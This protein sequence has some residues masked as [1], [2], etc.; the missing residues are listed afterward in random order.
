MIKK[1]YVYLAPVGYHL[2]VELDQTLSLS[3]DPRVN[4]SRPSIDVLFESAAYVLEEHCI[5]IVLTGANHDG[6]AGLRAIKRNGGLAIVQDPESAE[7]R[8]MPQ[9]AIETTEVDY[10]LTL[11]EMGLFL[12]KLGQC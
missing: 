4:Y 3:V 7:Y 10:V 5:G 6:S 1:G 9:S 12:Q 8:M 2:L 11:K